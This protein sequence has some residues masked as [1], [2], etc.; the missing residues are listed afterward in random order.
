MPVCLVEL[1]FRDYR[2]ITGE[3]DHIVSLGMFEHVGYKNYRTYMQ[4]VY[5]HLKTDGLF[6]LQTIGN[7]RSYRTTDPWLGKYIFPNSLIPSA[8]QISQAI[9]KLFVIEDWHNFGYDYSRTLLAWFNN[10]HAHWESLR[11]K[12]GDRFYRMWKYYLL[13]CAG[14]FRARKT[15]LWQIVL[16]KKGCLAAMNLFAKATLMGNVSVNAFLA[17][18]AVGMGVFREA[19]IIK[20]ET[21]VQVWKG[22]AGDFPLLV[23]SLRSSWNLFCFENNLNIRVYTFSLSRNL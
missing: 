18:F 9:E 13:A 6:L 16:S 21:H 8:T 14:S 20:R 19:P 5:D 10:F 22:M 4:K 17:D 3:Y 11:P 12:Y 15:N 23:C 2:D 1:Q 7:N